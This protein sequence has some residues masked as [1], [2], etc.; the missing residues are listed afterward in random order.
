[1]N[2]SSVFTDDAQL[3]AKNIVVSEGGKNLFLHKVCRR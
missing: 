3:G 2:H 1:M